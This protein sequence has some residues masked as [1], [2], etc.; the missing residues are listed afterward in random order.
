MA[1]NPVKTLVVDNFKGSMT[2]FFD[3]DINS[4]RSY[5]Q[6]VSG[7]NP[8]VKPG[9]LTWSNAPVQIDS[10]GSVI[11]DMIV[12]GKER[13]ESN[14][15]YVYAIG[16]TGRLYKI[17]VNDPTT[18]NP[19]YD[20]AV[21]L[22]TLTVQS[23]T[24]TRGGFIDF[25]GATEKIYIGHDKGVTS[26]DYVGTGEAFVGVLG[27]WTQDVPRPLRQFVG[28][29]YIGNGSNMAEIDTTATVTSYAKLSPGFP[30]GTQVRDLDI[31]L[32]GNYL[33]AVVT[34][35][36]LQDITSATQATNST[37]SSDSFIFKW[38]G[39]DTAPTAVDTFPS[40]ALTANT[41]FG[42]SQY[43]FGYDQY[44]AA[45]YNPTEKIISVT[46]GQSPLPNAI[47]SSG[48]L[49]T[50]ISPVSY[51]GVQ[52]LDLFAWGN[53][54]FEIGYPGNWDLMFMNATAPETDITLCP[55]ML[56]VS[57]TGLG[58]SSNGYANNL[59]GSSKI[60]F[61]TLETS[62]APTTKYRFYKWITT[63]SLVVPSG[64]SQ[65]DAVYQTQNQMFS[66]KSQIKNM[67]VYGEPWVANNA[68]QIDL[69]GSDNNPLTNGSYTFTAGTNLT[70]GD[71]MAYWTPQCAPTYT[72]G[73]RITNKGT[74]NNTINKI[75]IDYTAGGQ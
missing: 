16:H 18:Y 34:R 12:A 23:P 39:T 71:D 64:T 38:N 59:F 31:S 9:N 61:S 5:V 30:T 51:G 73:L 33:S 21:L 65:I 8:F 49:L 56:P 46:E 14:V 24:F 40:F 2:V 19:D 53:F 1:N 42:N 72:V 50:W 41:T 17:Q 54:D 68:F 66:K 10:A 26:V 20:N 28:K 7:A 58:A 75:E 3:G 44:G 27:S 6:T 63:N 11:T 32:A 60:Y 37:A 70:I 57:N 74:V 62:S 43:T 25:Y 13:L 45:V 35:I 52:E 47:A 15:L 22:T 69:I 4:G 67:R 55:F 29:L 48:N 36:P